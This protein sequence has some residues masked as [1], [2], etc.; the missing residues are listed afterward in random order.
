M[1][2]CEISFNS[3]LKNILVFSSQKR[4]NEFTPPLSSA[5]DQRVLSEQQLPNETNI[6]NA[7]GVNSVIFDNSRNAK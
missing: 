4:L 1:C 3:C 6:C 5:L 7:I 2:T